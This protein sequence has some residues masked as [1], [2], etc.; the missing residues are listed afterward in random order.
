MLLFVVSFHVNIIDY[1]TV[2]FG[3]LFQQVPIYADF[4][5]FPLTVFTPAFQISAQTHNSRLW[6]LLSGKHLED[7][8]ITT[9]FSVL[10][11]Y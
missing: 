7:L 8:S 11:I 6:S 2:F 1:S 4:L 3:H 9:A 5:H 10:H